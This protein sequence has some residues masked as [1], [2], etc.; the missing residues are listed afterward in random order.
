MRLVQQCIAE[1]V[2]TFFLVLFG[3]GAVAAAVLTGAQVG[4]WQ[5]A[6]V[7]GLGI[8]FAIYA[9]A[10]VSGAHLN[11]AVSLAFAL[12]R[13][14]D[15]P[16]RKLL[17]FWGAQ[18]LG[19]VLAGL[20]IF[21][22][23]NS[24][25]AS[26]EQQRGIVRGEPGS[27]FS[28]M[29]F[30]E[31]F[32][33]PAIFGAGEAARALISPAGAAAVEGLGTAILVFMIFALVD[34]RNTALPAKYLAP[35]LIGFTVAV[36]ISL[37]APLTQAGWNPARDFGPR[38]VAFFAGWGEVAIPGPRWGFWAYIAGPLV[39]GPIGA[40]LYDLLIRRALPQEAPSPLTGKGQGPS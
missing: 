16:A 1:T 34:R 35:P 7:W 38:I 5:V 33:N 27:E 23:F 6:V 11:P 21:S 37:F 40:A 3:T 29:V 17:P 31:Y 9:T 25:L 4:L 13:P 26:F 28:A 20:T 36:L 32:P 24:L 14:K 19:G 18:L 30:G 12:L 8:T 10:A 39:G 2:G 15:F 22:V